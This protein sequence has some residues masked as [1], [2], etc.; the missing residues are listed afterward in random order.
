MM[1]GRNKFPSWSA[2]RGNDSTI[3]IVNEGDE[4]HVVRKASSMLTWYPRQTKY[5]M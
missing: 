1:G 5:A 3:K 4:W 2:P